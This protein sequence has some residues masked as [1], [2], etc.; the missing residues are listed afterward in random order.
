MVERPLLDLYDWVERLLRRE[1]FPGQREGEEILVFTRR[2][3]F[4]LV[5]SI[6]APL[7]LLVLLLAFVTQ[8]GLWAQLLSPLGGFGF[9]GAAFLGL[10]L[11][12]G[13]VFW[14]FLEWENDHYIVTT[15][16]VIS[17]RRI[18]RV[19]EERRE[20]EIG[21]VQDVTTRI[22][23]LTATLLGYADLQIATAGVLGA[24]TF[25]RVGWPEQVAEVILR[26]RE[27]ASK[28]RLE[29][30]REAVKETLEREMGIR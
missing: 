13:L 4:F 14:A 11:A 27:A 30:S 21:R 10:L 29:T 22:P 15:E 26:Q 17:L 24:I 12:L 7:V 1:E 18:Y 2:H 28:E 19:Y 5:R 3:P 8:A 16:R 25:S 9:P 6:L 23:G 20:A